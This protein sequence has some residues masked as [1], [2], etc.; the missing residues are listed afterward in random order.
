MSREF[1]LRLP[2]GLALFVASTSTDG[3]AASSSTVKCV[4]LSD[5]TSAPGS[6]PLF[7]SAT[8]EE[9]DATEFARITSRSGRTNWTSSEG[10]AG[11]L[12]PDSGGACPAVKL[13]LAAGAHRRIL[14]H[15]LHAGIFSNADF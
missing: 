14:D 3:F 2:F 11:V 8:G 12:R 13:W 1:A 10:A 9:M 4:Q 7:T 5:P 6:T 15:D